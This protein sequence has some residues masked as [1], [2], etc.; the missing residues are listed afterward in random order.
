MP[1]GFGTADECFEVMTLIQT[2]KTNKFPIVLMGI[3]F[4]T[5]L[6]DWIKKFQL[7]NSY[8]N[9]EDLDLFSLTDDP[10][11]ACKIICDFHRGKKH[12]TNF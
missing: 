10:K 5:G 1:G 2:E 6:I 3:E 12:T 4:W 9:K 8:I 11:E 7:S